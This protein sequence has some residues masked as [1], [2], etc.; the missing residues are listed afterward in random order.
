MCVKLI[1]KKYRLE[2]C[3]CVCACVRACETHKEVS[4]DGDL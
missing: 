2:T 4:E 3:V 1:R